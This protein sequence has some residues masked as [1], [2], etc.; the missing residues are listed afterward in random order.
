[1]FFY[2][3]PYTD[4]HELNLDWIILMIKKMEAELKNFIGINTI[5]YADP[6]LWNITSQYEANTVVIDPQTGNA[7]IS[8]KAVPNGVH[9]NNTN[10]WTQIYNY[11][12]E[13]DQIRSNIATNEGNTTT[14]THSYNA[15]NLVWVQGNLYKVIAPIIPGDSFVVGSNIVAITIEDIIDILD[16]KIG[17]LNILNTADKSSLVNALNEVLG[18]IGDLTQLQTSDQTS[19]VNAINSLITDLIAMIGDLN[20]LNTSDK[21]SVVNAINSLITDIDTKIGDLTQ[22]DA[23][24]A[25][26]SSVV[27]ALN[28][29][30]PQVIGNVVGDGVKTYRELLD[31]L[32]ND[33]AAD[34]NDLYWLNKRKLKIDSRFGTWD[35]NAIGTSVLEF[36]NVH[37][38]LDNMS[39]LTA[40]AI[41]LQTSGSSMFRIKID[42]SQ[43]PSVTTIEDWSTNVAYYNSDFFRLMLI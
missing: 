14:S 28:S 3:Y 42:F 19:I 30:A 37:N 18:K 13:L 9:L 2:N 23:S 17:S 1:M 12:A 29:I 35:V 38:V 27:N 6:I 15:G 5:K 32:Y 11:A 39:Q 4:V 24:Y 22:L 31:E 21:T 40:F 25:D 43:T 8:T 26:K 33:V 10:Y 41:K 7:Y 36:Y 20:N 34:F 16:G